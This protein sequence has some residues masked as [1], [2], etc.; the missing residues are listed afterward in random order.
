MTWTVRFHPDTQADI[1]RLDRPARDAVLKAI[2]KKLTVDPEGYGE[3]LR[4]ELFGLWK[5]RVGDYR[6]VYRIEKQTI[7]VLV[8]K[9][10]LRRDREVYKEML[11]RLR[12]VL[13][14]YRGG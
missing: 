10:G 8:L 14:S 2:R 7:T 1:S 9:V 13:K 12:R 4:R 3:P 5:L 11:T 6:V